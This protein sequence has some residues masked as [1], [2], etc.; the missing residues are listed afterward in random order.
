MN[1]ITERFLSYTAI[2]TTSHD[3][4]TCPSNPNE[5]I[6]AHQLEDELKQLGLH[7][8]HVDEH[9]F[10]YGTL[11]ANT[12]KQCDTVGLLA[13]MDT[14]EA[15][16]GANVR[17]RIIENYDGGDIVHDGGLITAV[18]EYP[19]LKQLKGKSLIITDGTT[20]L[21]G[22]DKAGIAIIMDFLENAVN[23]QEYVHGEVRV[24]FT[25]DEETGMGI[26][27]INLDD[28]TCDYA[29][30]VDGG[31]INDVTYENFN[32][33]TA[34]VRFIGNSIHPG[35][36]KD[37][38]INALQLAIDYHGLLPEHQRPEH[39]EKREGF[40]H[41]VTLNGECA[42]ARSIY[43]LRNHDSELLEKQKDDFRNAADYMN[44]RYGK[45]V[46]DLDIRFGYRNMKEEFADRMF[47]IDQVYEVLEEM[48]H[49]PV[50]E[51][52]RGGTDGSKLTF[53]GIPTPNLGTGG[54]FCH[55]NHE[56]VCIEDMQEMSLILKK[57]IS[58][59]ER[60]GK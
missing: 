26:E 9:A 6:L 3:S 40:N 24:C 34:V 55:G 2:D 45:Q 38:M 48:G 46:V 11:P 42:E 59:I 39:T 20:L 49:K 43:I 54:H 10:V 17:T 41:L 28:F 37:K 51:P 21:G 57:L 36:A 25:P 1:R 52:V 13:H 35:D 18:S 58:H 56:M 53:M 14:S 19:D 8:V 15:A 23:D 5:F 12:E 31:D 44:H 7:D 60:K 47:I 22:D 33:A 30:T 16:S 27:N 29:Y 50:S 32:A 4:E